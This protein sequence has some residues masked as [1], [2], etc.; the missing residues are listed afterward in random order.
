MLWLSSERELIKERVK[1]GLENARRK[2]KR[3]GRK[4][5]PP[6][7]REKIIAAHINNP[8]LSITG[9]SKL[10]KQKHSSVY[11]TLSNF[12]AGKLDSQGFE[13]VRS[14]FKNYMIYKRRKES[15]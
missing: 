3:L 10:T 15:R 4:P 14:L 13:Y 2:G 11:K 1:A 12:R 5:L 7:V 6:I 9:L 8:S